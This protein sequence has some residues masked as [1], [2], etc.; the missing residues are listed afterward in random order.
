M[1][2]L[3]ARFYT[4]PQH[5]KGGGSCS[6]RGQ[7]MVGNI[8]RAD[9]FFI[10]NFYRCLHNKYDKSYYVTNMGAIIWQIHYFCIKEKMLI[11]WHV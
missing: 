9:V 5:G 3:G 1:M 10:D 11:G 6:V 7:G 2:K 8:F 4:R